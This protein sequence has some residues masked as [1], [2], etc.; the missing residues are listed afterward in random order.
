MNLWGL[1]PQALMRELAANTAM[2]IPAIRRSRL[3]G[4]RTRAAS[5]QSE[6]G[7][8]VAEFDFLCDSAGDIEGKVVLEIGPGDALGLAP[9]FI[10]AGAAGY[11][12]VDRFLGDIWGIGA[13]G[14]YDE[15]ERLRGP[16]ASG[17]REQVTLVRQSIEKTLAGVPRADVILSFDVIEHLLD[18]P[19]AVRNMSSLLKSD[20][21]MI[22]RVDYGPHGVW[23]STDDPLNFLS[24]PGWLWTAIGSNRGYPNR[25][26]HRQV[27][28]LLEAQGLRVAERITRRQG[29]DVM[30][31]ELACEFQAVP[32]LGR[33]FA[34]GP[35]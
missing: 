26:R 10:T 2:A 34:Q 24:V 27:V 12:A 29:T 25:V 23:L 21:R 5:P 35:A 11:I 14:L 32:R 3:K 22:H 16:F 15:L 33:P 13:K 30:D 6:A 4:L 7:K 19:H 20:G 31:A 1:R 17:W 9:L 28:Q 8:I 18:L